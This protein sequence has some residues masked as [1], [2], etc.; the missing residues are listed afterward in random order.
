MANSWVNTP[1]YFKNR[2]KGI[3]HASILPLDLRISLPILFESIVQSFFK[4]RYKL[5]FFAVISVRL[6]CQDP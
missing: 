5:K 2:T 4:L 1:Q 3:R 6:C